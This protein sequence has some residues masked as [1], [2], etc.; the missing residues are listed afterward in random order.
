MPIQVP[1]R[2]SLVTRLLLS[3][4]LLAGCAESRDPASP[5]LDMSEYRKVMERQKSELAAQESADAPT[6]EMSP[7]EHER[8]GDQDAARR[9][10]P[11]AGVHYGKALKADPARNS[12]RLKLGQILLQQGLF[13][14]ALTQFQDLQ[15]RDPKSAPAHQ[16]I[17]QIYLHQGKLPEAEAALSKAIALDPS[18][19][20]SHNLLG[21]VYD[22]GEHHTKAIAAYQSALAIQPREAGVLNNLGLAYALSGDHEEAVRTYE[23]AAATG[24]A[25]PKLFNNL[26]IAYVYRQRY[27]D[28]LEAFKKATD[29]PRAYNNLGMTLLGMGNSRKAA[30][31]FE[32][33][34]EVNPQY[35]EKATENLR[36]AQQAI[37]TTSTENTSTE[38]ALACP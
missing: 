26:G 21:L 20:V 32:K 6:Q 30:I 38:P 23:Q 14:A 5:S 29:E 9:N 34:I 31:C 24:S 7:E 25:S 15:T 4:A 17:G 19:W 27:A 37:K 33:A 22:Q 10:F 3:G 8:A 11:L 18:S 2:R 35:Y 13:D 16:S 28:A 12:V 1:R 36:K